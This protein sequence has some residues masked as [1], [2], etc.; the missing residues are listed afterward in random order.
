[1]SGTPPAPSPPPIEFTQ[2]ARLLGNLLGA[3]C[4]PLH[5]AK[6]WRL[7]VVFTLEQ[8]NMIAVFHDLCVKL[9]HSFQHIREAA[10][11]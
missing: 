11:P 6:G 5:T 7:G 2:A 9:P 3:P 8:I 1:M 4:Q 10:D